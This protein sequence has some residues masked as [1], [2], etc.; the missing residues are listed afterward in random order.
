MGLLLGASVMTIFELLDLIFYNLSVKLFTRRDF[1]KDNKEKLP[2]DT[3]E[4][5]KSID[6]V[7]AV[8][9]AG[10]YNGPM[11]V[12]D[13]ETEEPPNGPFTWNTSY[14]DFKNF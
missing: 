5:V 10:G 4:D 8:F 7:E 1:S 6:G 12:E 2:P 13:L 9:E 11:V 14:A 3:F